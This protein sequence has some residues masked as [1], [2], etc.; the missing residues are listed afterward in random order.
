[1]LPLGGLGGGV[2]PLGGLEWVGIVFEGRFWQKACWD[3]LLCG[4][5]GKRRW[6]RVVD[7]MDE[8]AR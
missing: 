1:M 8:L 6:F 7:S 5:A 4:K 2:L 3:V